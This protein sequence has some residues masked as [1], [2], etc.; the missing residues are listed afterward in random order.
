MTLGSEFLRRFMEMLQVSPVSA[1]QTRILRDES[2]EELCKAFEYW[3]N[4]L[5]LLF[6]R[7]PV[8]ILITQGLH[9]EGVDLLVQTADAR[10]KLGMQISARMTS[11]I[12]YST[13]TFCPR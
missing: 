10:T 1:E 7:Q 4:Q 13:R 5:R 2:H 9:D 11:R 12:T 8:E 6:G 3:F